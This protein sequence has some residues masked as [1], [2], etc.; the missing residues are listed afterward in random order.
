MFTDVPHNGLLISALITVLCLMA[1]G[2]Y[3]SKMTGQKPLEGA[4]KTTAI[5][6]IAASAAYF[7]ARLVSA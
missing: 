2:Y 5:G 3:K 1:F 6:I 4:L 7:I